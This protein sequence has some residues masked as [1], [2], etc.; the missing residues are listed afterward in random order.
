MYQTFATCYS[1]IAFLTR[2]G[3]QW[4]MSLLFFYSSFSLLSLLYL[5]FSF[6]SQ[7]LSLYQPVFF[8]FLQSDA[9]G[10]EEGDDSSQE[11]RKGNWRMGLRCF[12][13]LISLFRL[14]LSCGFTVVWWW[15]LISLICWVCHGGERLRLPLSW[16]HRWW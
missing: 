2:Y 1:T 6:S 14:K 16:V 15:W 4:N 12:W 11:R 3:Q 7:N 9:S 8:L 10:A 13:F 5:I